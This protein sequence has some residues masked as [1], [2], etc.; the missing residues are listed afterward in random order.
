MARTSALN[1]GQLRPE[2][3]IIFS[4]DDGCVWAS[5]PDRD[6]SAVR[7]GGYHAVTAMMRDFLAQSALAERLNGKDGIYPP[8]A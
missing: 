8:L 3:E 1:E 2:N 5:W 7:L 6:S 4:L